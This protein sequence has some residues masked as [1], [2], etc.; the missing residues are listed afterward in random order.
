[1]TR[2]IFISYRREDAPDA[3]GR[4]YDLLKSEL[5]A[6]NLFLDVDGHS[7]KPGDD[8]VEVLKSHVSAADAVLVVIG[9]RWAELMAARK[10]D[11]NDWVYI[12]I[13]AALDARKQVIPILVGRA[14]MPREDTLPEEIRPLARRS[15]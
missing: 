8:F 7:I 11:P 5:P 3:A 2:R 10:G 12:E 9:P 14:R 13:R 1:M 15:A 6:C 4:L